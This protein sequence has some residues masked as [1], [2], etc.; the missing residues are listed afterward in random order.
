MATPYG[1]CLGVPLVRRLWCGLACWLISGCMG[2]GLAYK[3]PIA[4]KYRHLSTEMNIAL[5]MVFRPSQHYLRMD[6]DSTYGGQTWVSRAK[7]PIPM[8]S[9]QVKERDLC[10]R[11]E[12]P[13][14]HGISFGE[15][16][17]AHPQVIAEMHDWLTHLCERLPV[18]VTDKV[19]YDS[20]HSREA[21]IR[22]LRVSMGCDGAPKE[23]RQIH[24]FVVRDFDNVFN[25]D[26]GHTD[27]VLKQSIIRD[28]V[29][30]INP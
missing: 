10:N 1:R 16:L 27:A 26:S 25:G 3:E 19:I 22:A 14:C 5:G 18:T 8:G 2:Y 15:E 23:T 4:F 17:L 11:R 20:V 24:V 28:W 30:T 21:S 6:A 7:G 29:I 9:A 13:Y 12:N